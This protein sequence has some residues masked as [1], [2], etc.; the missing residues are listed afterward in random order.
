MFHS[1]IKRD[2]PKWLASIMET[3]SYIFDALCFG[4]FGPK[5]SFSLK[6]KQRIRLE[7]IDCVKKE[8]GQANSAQ[9]ERKLSN[10]YYKVNI[11]FRRCF[12]KKWRS[13]K[14]FSNG[15]NKTWIPEMLAGMLE[16][17]VPKVLLR[18]PYSIFALYI[19]FA[20]YT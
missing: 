7:R 6:R 3:H 9:K 18:S 2:V 13:V 5:K 15:R 14:S 20:I 10:I 12:W 16:F 17:N 4:F 19:S 11:L 8:F 1:K